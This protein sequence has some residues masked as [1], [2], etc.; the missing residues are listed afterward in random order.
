MTSVPPEVVGLPLA[1][2]Q[3]LLDS[4]GVRYE[5]RVTAARR[6]GP[7]APILASIPRVIQQRT[8]PAGTVLVAAY[9]LES[10]ERR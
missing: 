4:A 7:G 3:V 6:C 5:L 8:S 2:A 9:P 1:E 10:P